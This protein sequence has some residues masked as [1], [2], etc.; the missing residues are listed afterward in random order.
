MK[1]GNEKPRLNIL[2]G[3]GEEE[4]DKVFGKFLSET[5]QEEYA[6]SSIAIKKY[7]S[8]EIIKISEKFNFDIFII[9]LNNIIPT[10]AFNRDLNRTAE[11]YEILRYLKKRYQK[12]IIGLYGSALDDID[13]EKKVLKAGAD[14]C[15]LIPFELEVLHRAV[16]ECL[17]KQKTL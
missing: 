2:L 8:S 6:V 7:T 14:C 10:D 9:L 11:V 4:L 1:S 16:I 12:P 15:L 13:F 5:F 17:N 3:S